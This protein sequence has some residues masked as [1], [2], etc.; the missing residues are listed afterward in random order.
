MVE[1][2]CEDCY[3]RTMDKVA[4]ELAEEAATDGRTASAG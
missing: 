3:R 2:L 1:L 4:R